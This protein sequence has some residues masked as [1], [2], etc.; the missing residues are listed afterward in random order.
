MVFNKR[1]ALQDN[2]IALQTAFTL[3]SEARP[4]SQQEMEQLRRYH[5]FGG[6]KFILNAANKPEDIA[7]WPKSD[8]SYFTLTSKRYELVK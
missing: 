2:I 4:A 8:R 5:G 7:T 3:E 1:G 6:L